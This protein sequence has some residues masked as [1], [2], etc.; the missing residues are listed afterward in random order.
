MKFFIQGI[1]FLTSAMSFAQDW[2]ASL[3]TARAVDYLSERDKDVIFEMNKLRSDPSRY[4]REVLTPLRALFSGRIINWPGETPIRTQE[5]VRALDEAIRELNTANP[6]P[7]LMPSLG[8]CRA[9]Q[10]HADEQ[11]RTG[12]L[13]HNGS[14]GSTP[15]T[16]MN[17]FGRWTGTA[18]ENIEYGSTTGARSIIALIIDDGVPGRGHRKNL[19]N[20]AFTLAGVGSATHRQYRHVTVIAYAGGYEEK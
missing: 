8:M 3:D 12:G 4:A 20:R 11:A 1:L 14:D 17:R 19:F 2:D 16:R 15:F 10:S 18:G 7:S 13:G 6:L 9:A 5:G